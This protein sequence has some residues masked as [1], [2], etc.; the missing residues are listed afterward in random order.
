MINT[1]TF[2]D[3]I[4]FENSINRK[5]I[6]VY[7]AVKTMTEIRNDVLTYYRGKK[8][9]RKSYPLD[10]H[11]I[12]VRAFDKQIYAMVGIRKQLV[13]TIQYSMGF[14][15]RYA[16]W[17]I[18]SLGLEKELVE[19]TEIVLLNNKGPDHYADLMRMKDT[20]DAQ[21]ELIEKLEKQIIDQ[22]N[23]IQ[24]QFDDIHKQSVIISEQKDIIQTQSKKLYEL[25]VINDSEG[26]EMG[27]A[28]DDE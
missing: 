9:A 23:R 19:C 25:G 8:E 12:I 17:N 7:D 15:S 24:K 6:K 2:E 16:E 28:S 10:L 20:I 1:K 27:L 14:S 4:E 11:K 18:I 26:D 3:D 21:N 5:L 22:S 13:D